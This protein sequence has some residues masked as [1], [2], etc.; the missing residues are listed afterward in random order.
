MGFSVLPRP[1]AQPR[2]VD[3]TVRLGTNLLAAGAETEAIEEGN[4]I[5]YILPINYTKSPFHNPATGKDDRV[6]R[7][8]P[9]RGT[10]R[11]QFLLC[12]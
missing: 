10:D 1:E 5:H 2:S 7:V 11:F 12:L 9:A 4:E 3:R 6:L 8:R